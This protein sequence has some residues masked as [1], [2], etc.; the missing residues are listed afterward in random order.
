[1][2]F[3]AWAEGRNT[4][5]W[6]VSFASSLIKKKLVI[7]V[8]V[9]YKG[10]PRSSYYYLKNL[11]CGPAITK[12]YLN[13]ITFIWH[14]YQKI[15][16]IFVVRRTCISFEFSHEIGENI[17]FSLMSLR[18][19]PI[20]WMSK[21]GWMALIKTRRYEKCAWLTAAG[22]SWAKK[23]EKI[24]W[25]KNIKN[26]LRS[27]KKWSKDLTAGKILKNENLETITFF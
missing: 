15:R 17:C 21:I 27:T 13:S 23:I 12:L 7:L 4:G 26:S 10:D 1:M 8:S 2:W 25:I 20:V 9:P 19:A 11:K 24:F 5:L 3:F 18:C 22:S 16:I 14:L 6:L